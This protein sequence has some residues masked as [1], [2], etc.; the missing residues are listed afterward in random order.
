MPPHPP[1]RNR[2]IQELTIRTV[3][4]EPPPPP[5]RDLFYD[6]PVARP[7]KL[8]RQLEFDIEGGAVTGAA[9]QL[10]VEACAADF[11]LL[12]YFGQLIGS[13]LELGDCTAIVLEESG[14]RSSYRQANQADSA[15]WSVRMLP[16]SPPSS[17]VD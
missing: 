10:E 15:S 13:N 5:N 3:N 9:S 17:P 1:A 4:D 6:G 2:L 14:Q 8:E 7:L 12:T 11:A 16:V